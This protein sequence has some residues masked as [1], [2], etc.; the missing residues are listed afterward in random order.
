MAYLNALLSFHCHLASQLDPKPFKRVIAF[1]FPLLR[2]SK[3]HT[4]D[5][6]LTAAQSEK[7][8]KKIKSRQP[9]QFPRRI[10]VQG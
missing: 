8:K 6:R 10:I 3:G 7:K 1:G 2:K 5:S 9:P 4:L